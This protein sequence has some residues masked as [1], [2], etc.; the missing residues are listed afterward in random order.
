VIRNPEKQKIGSSIMCPQPFVLRVQ[1]GEPAGVEVADHIVDPVLAGE[2]NLRDHGHVYALRGQQHHLRPTPSHHHP[3]PRRTI[4]TSRRPSSSISRTRRRSLTRPVRRISGARDSYPAK[5]FRRVNVICYGTRDQRSS[6]DQL[7]LARWGPGQASGDAGLPR[8][9]LW[10]RLSCRSHAS[11]SEQRP[12]TLKCGITGKSCYESN[13]W[14]RRP[15]QWEAQVAWL[16]EDG[17][18]L[19]NA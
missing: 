9:I 1:R 11:A 13:N 19:T 3:L 17:D 15:L 8:R 16:D 2:G 5:A 12:D 7:L 4:R 18:H 6:R 14:D 10:F